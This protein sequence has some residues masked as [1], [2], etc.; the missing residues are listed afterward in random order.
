[1]VGDL[2]TLDYGS[3]VVGWCAC[4]HF[5]DWAELADVRTC[6]FGA[7]ILSVISHMSIL[8]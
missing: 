5:G 3:K 1:M 7:G 8:D 2:L 6:V 4:A